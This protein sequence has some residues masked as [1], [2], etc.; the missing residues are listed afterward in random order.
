MCLQHEHRLDGH[1]FGVEL[2]QQWRPRL[3]AR[4]DEHCRR[5]AEV[6]LEGSVV[7]DEPCD[8]VPLCVGHRLEL[9]TLHHDRELCEGPLAEENVRHSDALPLIG[10]AEALLVLLDVVFTNTRV[11]LQVGDLGGLSL[12]AVEGGLVGGAPLGILLLGG[13]LCASETPLLARRATPQGV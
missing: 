2:E 7:V 1:T 9:V 8:E 3:V 13:S 10:D 6:Q 12:E 11:V 4:G 5:V